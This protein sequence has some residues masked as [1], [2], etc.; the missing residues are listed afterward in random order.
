MAKVK[1]NTVTGCMVDAHVKEATNSENL[2]ERL[3]EAKA[4]LEACREDSILKKLTWILRMVLGMGHRGD[5][6]E[7]PSEFR[8]LVFEFFAA[9]LILANS[10]VLGLE[11]EYQA[12]HVDPSPALT[13]LSLLFANWFI[14]EVIIR[15]RVAGIVPYFCN[16]EWMWNWTDLIL[17]LVSIIELAFV[18]FGDSG[19]AKSPVS[20]LRAIKII[21]VVRLFRLLRFFRQLATLALMVAH[22]VQQLLWALVM[23][24]LIM[25]VLAITLTGS[26]TDWLKERIDFTT[27]EWEQEI[28]DSTE[29]GVTKVYT[30]F[31]SISRSHYTL[32]QTTLGGV[33]WYEVTDAL[34]NVDA[35][36]CILMFAYIIFTILALMNV[37]TGVFVDNALQNS[38]KERKTQ[39]E[40]TIDRK[41]T[42]LDQIIEF[43]V[44][45]DSNGDGTISADEI[46]FLLEDPMM[47]AYFDMIGFRPG[48][49]K[50]L[51]DLLDYDNS[52][53]ISLDEFISGC[54]RMRGEAK[55]IDV[56]LL[57][58]EC[59]QI[60]AKLDA[61][62]LNSSKREAPP[63]ARR[64]RIKI[65]KSRSKLS[66]SSR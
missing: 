20:S 29:T 56:H 58:M 49:A 18:A 55:G 22:S 38:K 39:I 6:G 42:A 57:M 59:Y 32:F 28:L 4:K 11:V 16:E 23:F 64:S 10:I 52:G 3:A 50:L 13:I 9:C 63:V 33:S 47:S 43:F 27:A 40:D 44:A 30:Y 17:V 46:Q 48:D 5:Y 14:I 19:N 2:N 51:A 45:T 31:G 15:V 7:K 34:F 41:R 8:W 37:F 60:N 1:T 35:F 65:Q 66:E 53:D 21:R 62:R 36:S 12:S 61:L 54:E 26:C 25:Y 24:I